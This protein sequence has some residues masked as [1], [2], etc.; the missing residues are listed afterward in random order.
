MKQCRW[1]S[2]RD[3]QDNTKHSIISLVDRAIGFHVAA[4]YKRKNAFAWWSKILKH[5]IRIFG[6]PDRLEIDFQGEGL[7]DYVGLRAQELGII[8]EFCPAEAHWSIGHVEVSQEI[9]KSRLYRSTQAAMSGEISLTDRLAMCLSTKNSLA[10][11]RGYSPYQWVLGACPQVIGNPP[12]GNEIFSDT[13]PNG[14]FNR[15]MELREVA[16]VVFIKV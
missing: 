6:R 2:A 14:S 5:W 10:R 13:D 4:L 7:S 16:R 1:I 15:N 3:P 9:L 12:A 8:I 11:H